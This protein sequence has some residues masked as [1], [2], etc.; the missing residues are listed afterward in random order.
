MHRSMPSQ[1]VSMPR[2][3]AQ[4]DVPMEPVGQ[5]RSQR[6]PEGRVSLSA[7]G[8]PEI[9]EELD[10]ISRMCERVKT[11]RHNMCSH[12]GLRSTQAQPHEGEEIMDRAR[13][14]LKVLDIEC[15]LHERMSKLEQEKNE[16]LDPRRFLVD[17]KIDGY[18]TIF[19]GLAAIGGIGYTTTLSLIFGGVRGQMEFVRWAS[20][21]FAIGFVLP[22]LVRAT[23]QFPVVH[24]HIPAKLS[25]L[26]PI[27]VVW[28]FLQEA[29]AFVFLYVAMVA[30]D[31]RPEFFADA[32]PKIVPDPALS[33]IGNF[34]PGYVIIGG[35][36]VVA[37]PWAASTWLWV[38]RHIRKP[39]PEI[40]PA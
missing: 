6:S 26:L 32:T 1:V 24:H 33:G 39:V 16:I 14:Y 35:V 8:T 3:T 10:F 29:L 25:T 5:S 34:I 27:F 31:F 21:F 7:P 37:Y 4:E 17:D 19:T 2:N 28:I 23:L 18:C 13:E 9:D 22:A 38:V 12:N 15:Q 11:T 20:L 40:S 36:L 30:L